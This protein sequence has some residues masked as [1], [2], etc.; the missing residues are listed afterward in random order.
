[1]RAQHGARQVT[2]GGWNLK[3]CWI[4]FLRFMR[5][6]SRCGTGSHLPVAET[7][8]SSCSAVLLGS[9]LGFVRAFW[10]K[11]QLPAELS[12]DVSS[13]PDGQADT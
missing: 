12:L 10:G 2:P 3:W 1:M 13:A 5:R 8:R 7:R 6:W 9:D 11:A 4:P